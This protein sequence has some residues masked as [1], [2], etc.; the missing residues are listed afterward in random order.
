MSI[1]YVIAFN[2]ALL[3]AIASPG[4]AL[5]VAIRTTLVGGRTAGI[6][7][8]CGLGLMAA[9]WTLM[10]LLGLD[11]IF[12]VFPWAYA[13]AKIVGALYLLYLAWTTWRGAKKPITDASKPRVHAFRDG[14]LIN[15]SNPKS[16]LFAAAVLIV[17][18]P[19][20]LTMIEKAMVVTNHFLVE[21]VF[22]GLLAFSMSTEA[23]SKT[24]LRA[25]VFL[26]RFA[27]VVLGAL[28]LRLLLQR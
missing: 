6:A 20:D 3:A 22:Y 4:P 26:D 7:I 9:V 13:T 17:I 8:G 14:V 10:A 18:F 11:G 23:V 21:L 24:Y 16:V 5:L 27:A 28:G 1:E 12:R 19:P 2:I 15:I 25:K